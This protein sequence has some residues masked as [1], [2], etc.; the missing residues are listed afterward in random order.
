MD[1]NEKSLR[2]EAQKIPSVDLDHDLSVL[3]DLLKLNP[4]TY[5][6]FCYSKFHKLSRNTKTIE[7][8]KK[9][10]IDENDKNIYFPLLDIVL[11]SGDPSIC[12]IFHNR[13]VI[14]KAEKFDLIMS[15]IIIND[16]FHSIKNSLLSSL[17]NIIPKK[18]E[19]HII[20]MRDNILLRCLETDNSFKLAL[21]C[22]EKIPVQYNINFFQEFASIAAFLINIGCKNDKLS[23]LIID[24]LVERRDKNILPKLLC[25][26][27]LR[28]PDL[29]IE[30]LKDNHYTFDEVDISSR[31]YKAKLSELPPFLIPFQIQPLTKKLSG[32]RLCNS[33]SSNP[34]EFRTEIHNRVNS[35]QSNFNSQTI[36]PLLL[37]DYLIALNEPLNINSPFKF[38]LLASA[39]IN[40]SN[41]SNLFTSEFAK[42]TEENDLNMIL[43]ACKGLEVV[44]SK[45]SNIVSTLFPL[46]R[47]F[48]NEIQDKRVRNSLLTAIAHAVGNDQLDPIFIWNEYHS[49]LTIPKASN[50]YEDLIH[51]SVVS[52]QDEYAGAVAAEILK[53]LLQIDRQSV[54]SAF[55]RYPM[56]KLSKYPYL[57]NSLPDTHEVISAK[58][59]YLPKIMDEELLL[60]KNSQSQPTT[61]KMLHLATAFTMFPNVFA[62]YNITW[63][64]ILVK[65]GQCIFNLEI[66]YCFYEEII[67]L[68]T[69]STD[70][71]VR[72]SCIFSLALFISYRLI[73]PVSSNITKILEKCSLD[74]KS[75]LV[76]VISL[77]GYSLCPPPLQTEFFVQQ[78]IQ[79]AK[80]F[81]NCQ[82]YL[83]GIGYCI[84]SWYSYI[85]LF[86]KKHQTEYEQL[87]GLWAFLA[88]INTF[89]H[90]PIKINKFDSIGMAQFIYLMRENPKFDSLSKEYITNGLTPESMLVATCGYI[91]CLAFRINR[92]IPDERQLSIIK[93]APKEFTSQNE[94]NLVNQLLERPRKYHSYIDRPP[95]QSNDVTIVQK[96]KNEWKNLS[97]EEVNT[98]L[99]L[100][101]QTTIQAIINDGKEYSL[102]V[103]ILCKSLTDICRLLLKKR[104]DI[105]MMKMVKQLYPHQENLS[106]MLDKMLDP[107]ENNNVL[108]ERIAD[109]LVYYNFNELLDESY[110]AN[111]I[112]I[113]LARVTPMTKNIAKYGKSFPHFAHCLMLKNYQFYQKYPEHFTL[114]KKE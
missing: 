48:L 22:L 19:A 79:S 35:I 70:E 57:V 45:Y 28:V 29:L 98:I 30:Y 85:S 59:D 95:K 33:F 71:K 68:S 41:I 76:R 109:V 31:V 5:F 4:N 23:L 2:E 1:L 86:L 44:S 62:K 92:Y 39:S 91:P 56:S 46:I 81:N 72:F 12:N 58:N 74:D 13:S 32:S 27:S 26:S 60:L 14:Q 52:L 84:R 78:I 10:I 6:D 9:I 40:D 88:D 77:Y 53:Q 65:A 34:D 80:A 55:W 99:S 73:Y 51:Y 90:Q 7:E 104:W 97:N 110:S 8:L 96:L 108:Q 66:D 50:D 67:K 94:Y 75:K 54:I 69:E 47:K 25:H 42:L 64:S 63:I 83:I 3:K 24:T 107:Q 102:F 21:N 89:W 105:T 93:I 38:T 43:A 101:S 18:A 20:Q 82:E 16:N 112:G 111:L 113:L 87:P 114:F 37:H 15:A 11:S 17:F 100:L 61:L 49:V 106:K 103:A 36:D